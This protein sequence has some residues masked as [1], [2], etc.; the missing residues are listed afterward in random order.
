MSRVRKSLIVFVVVLLAAA[1]LP[2]G[3][4]LQEA[5]DARPAPDSVLRVGVVV[6]PIEDRFR[7]MGGVTP[8][9]TNIFET[10]VHLN[11]DMSIRPGLATSWSMVNPTTWRI[12]LRRGVRFHSGR[13]FDAA[14]VKLSLETAVRELGLAG[15]TR[16]RS[17]RVVDAHTVHIETTM[18][19][20]G[21]PEVL[22]H[23][24]TKIANL[25]QTGQ[26]RP[27]GT[28]P[29]RYVSHDRDVQMVVERNA[30]Y[31]G[32]PAR[33]ERVVFRVIPDPVTRLMALMRGEVDFIQSLDFGSIGAVQRNPR[34]QLHKVTAPRVRAMWFNV[35]RP[36]VDD[37]RVRRAI[38]H[39]I[40]RKAIVQHV[41]AGMGRVATAHIPP[42][43]PWSIH[44]DTAGYAYDPARAR[45]LLS[46]AGW[47]AIGADGIRVRGGA[48]LE[49][50]M[51]MTIVDPMTMPIAEAVQAMLR[52]VGVSL[53][54][55]VLERGAFFA[56]I[57][58][59]DPTMRLGGNIVASGYG[60][61][62]LAQLH[63]DN[64]DNAA[65]RQFWIGPHVD[66]LIDRAAGTM[67]RRERFDLYR[68]IQ[69]IWEAEAMTVPIAYDVTVHA[70]GRHVHDLRLHATDWSQR[71]HT[72]AIRR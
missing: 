2:V 45:A 62:L 57:R 13:L 71:W 53:R 63:R 37:A 46:E 52:E 54:L 19:F 25:E 29:F 21:L 61:I 39:A 26:V 47:T 12:D 69:R 8:Y 23:P 40:D 60:G 59:G 65:V 28:G 24:I 64:I 38:N 58:R 72:V 10:L 7:F 33:V 48:R 30:A 32:P 31:W 41:L 20:G 56:A 51:I 35:R 6:N 44:A 11:E 22:S 70:S 43:M 27:D 1:L 66:E 5:A 49:I 14:A 16:I 67:S 36:P 15:W 50:E 34:L 18:P 9:G 4:P 42:Q 55:S 17:V 3:S 68:Q